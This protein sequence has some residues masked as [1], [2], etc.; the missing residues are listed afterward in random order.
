MLR[1]LFI[2]SMVFLGI[3]ASAADT[4]HVPAGIEKVMVFAGTWKSESDQYDTAYS[5][6]GHVAVTT[7]NDC[8][9][10]GNYYACNQ[11]V[12]GQSRWLLV[13]V[14][15]GSGDTYGVYNV[16]ADGTPG[17]PGQ[18]IIY[19]KTWTF[20]VQRNNLGKTTYFR[21]VNTFTDANHYDFRQEYS[22]DKENW[23]VMVQGHQTR[24]K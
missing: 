3:A 6:A 19:D 24:I 14:Y 23:T 15:P 1:L 11:S 5:K 16:P 22:E 10:N 21:T 2:A 18:L 4:G 9:R 12:N 20:P 13:F 7:V 17:I 8:F